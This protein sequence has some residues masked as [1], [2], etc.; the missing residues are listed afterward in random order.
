MLQCVAV[1]LFG[2]GFTVTSLQHTAKHCNTLQH[3]ALHCNDSLNVT[4]CQQ[5][6]RDCAVQAARQWRI[7]QMRKNAHCRDQDHAHPHTLSLA[8]SLSLLNCAIRKTNG[9]GCAS[10]RASH[11]SRPHTLSLSLSRWFSLSHTCI[12][13]HNTNK[14]AP[15]KPFVQ[16]IVNHTKLKVFG[17]VHGSSV[18]LLSNTVTLYPFKRKGFGFTNHTNKIAA[19]KTIA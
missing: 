19:C 10:S 3:T 4:R 12:H 18:D 1:D 14:I 11:R 13:T 9:C 7:A 16:H 8:R 15:Y 2:R 5:A 6:A 17:Q